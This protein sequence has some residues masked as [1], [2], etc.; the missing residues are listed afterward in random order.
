MLPAMLAAVTATLLQQRIVKESIYTL[1]LRAE[2]IGLGA[3]T[4]VS[5]LRRISVDQ[6]PLYPAEVIDPGE[7]ATNL[8]RLGE[9]RAARA[10]VVMD[11]QGK[12]LGLVT[13]YDIRTMMLAPDSVGLLLAGDL[14]RSEVP[15]LSP[16]DTLDGAFEAFSRFEVDYLPVFETVA[17]RKQLKGLLS[18]ADLMRRYHAELVS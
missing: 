7:P 16:S 8:I 15:P 11:P 14:V 9:P 17:G 4:G 3:P 13:R 1:P 6:V 18:R 12:Y 2:G 5:A 10:L